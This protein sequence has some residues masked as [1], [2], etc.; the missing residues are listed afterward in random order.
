MKEYNEDEKFDKDLFEIKN[1]IDEFKLSDEFK[2]DLQEKLDFEYNKEETKK[3]NLFPSF[4][5]KLVAAA[6][7]CIL[8]LSGCATFAD[9]VENWVTKI[10]SNTDKIVEKAIANGNY[11][12]INMDYVENNGVSIKV[13]YIVIENKNLYIAFNV[14]SEI[15]SNKVF[16]EGIEIKNQNN[17]ILYTSEPKEG[18][19][20]FINEDFNINTQNIIIICKLKDIDYELNKLEKIKFKINEINLLKNKEGIKKKGIWEFEI[21]I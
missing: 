19:G 8:L 16:I 5:Q 18:N 17:N 6:A 14:M 3:K 20:T 12:E 13:D 2:S 7:C 4:S 15:E 21:D 10:F 9:E 1:K 11:K